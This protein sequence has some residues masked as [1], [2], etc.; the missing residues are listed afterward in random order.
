MYEQEDINVFNEE[1]IKMNNFKNK[2]NDKNWVN[3]NDNI[4]KLKI[5]DIIIIE[6]YP[7][8]QKYI[9]D[10]YPKFGVIT[11]ILD[12]QTY[13]ND[14]LRNIILNNSI[15][16]YDASHGQYNMYSRGYDYSITKIQNPNL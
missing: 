13:N 8:S 14:L 15:I 10:L 7:N 9:Y 5:N 2:F 11:K 16:E 3:I 6:Y 12:K 1:T 4:D